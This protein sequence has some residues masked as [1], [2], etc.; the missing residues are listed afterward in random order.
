MAF[1]S[2]FTPVRGANA[3]AAFA[4]DDSGAC[5]W[6]ASGG[7]DYQRLSHGD[8]PQLVVFLEAGEVA[9]ETVMP[10]LPAVGT[11][12][13]LGMVPLSNEWNSP[14]P[15]NRGDRAGEVK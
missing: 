11:P 3:G 12:A 7:G 9:C 8:L 5:Y 1:F 14:I 10:L 13:S 15:R 2:E 4:I 6:R